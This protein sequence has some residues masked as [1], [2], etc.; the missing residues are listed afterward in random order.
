MV[1]GM[2]VLLALGGVVL[3]AVVVA[4]LGGLGLASRKGDGIRRSGGQ[5]KSSARQVLDE[6]FARGEIGSEEYE[7]IRAQLERQEGVIWDSAV[8]AWAGEDGWAGAE[9]G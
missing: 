8:V 4:V 2:L 9:A 5:G 7:A 3:A 1:L 6:R